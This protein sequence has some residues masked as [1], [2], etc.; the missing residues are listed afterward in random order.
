MRTWHLPLIV[1]VLDRVITWRLLRQR[2]KSVHGK[3]EHSIAEIR[4]T[5]ICLP[6]IAYT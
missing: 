4:S 1:V 6:V 3:A 2:L 5:P